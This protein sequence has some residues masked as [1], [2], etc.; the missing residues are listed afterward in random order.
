M[1]VFYYWRN[2]RKLFSKG[3]FVEEGYGMTH[4]DLVSVTE[5]SDYCCTLQ[6]IR[7][8]SCTVGRLSFTEDLIFT[9]SSSS[10]RSKGNCLVL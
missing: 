7:G 1:R 4:Q 10:W 3:L 5:E 6:G 2:S 8:Q 9:F